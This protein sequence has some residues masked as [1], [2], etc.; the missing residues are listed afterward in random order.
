MAK[1]ECEIKTSHNEKVKWNSLIGEL[2]SGGDWEQNPNFSAPR[3]AAVL[4]HVAL[5]LHYAPFGAHYTR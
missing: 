3:F 2:R 1:K 5:S 4:D